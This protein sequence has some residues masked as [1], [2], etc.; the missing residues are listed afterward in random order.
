MHPQLQAI[1]ILTCAVTAFALLL[2]I[3]QA[4]ITFR[5]GWA[6]TLLNIGMI[7]LATAYFQKTLSRIEGNPATIVDVWRETSLLLVVIV[8]IAMCVRRGRI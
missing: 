8:R 5:D 1:S 4:P 2:R 3:R 6:G 7:S